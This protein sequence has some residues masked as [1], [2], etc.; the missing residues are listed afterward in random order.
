MFKRNL[1]DHEVKVKAARKARRAQERRNRKADRAEERKRLKEMPVSQLW[2]E[3][4]ADFREAKKEW[5]QEKQR[6]AEAALNAQPLEEGEWYRI[7]EQAEREVYDG[8]VSFNGPR[9]EVRHLIA[10]LKDESTRLW[11]YVRQ[12]EDRLNALYHEG[13]PDH[14]AYRRVARDHGR[15]KGFQEAA[16]EL[17]RRLFYSQETD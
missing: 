13:R 16:L 15:A 10:C 6:A 14:A 2:A 12:E 5:D 3:A 7:K 11:Q 1:T 17:S 9:N 4:K 8:A